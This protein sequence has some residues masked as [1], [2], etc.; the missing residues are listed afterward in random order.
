MRRTRLVLVSTGEVWPVLEGDVMFTIP[1]FIQPEIISRCDTQEAAQSEQDINARVTILKRL[2]ELELSVER[3]YSR[4]LQRSS[5]ALH[6]L[7]RRKPDEWAKVTVPTVAKSVMWH[8][9]DPVVSLLCVHKCLMDQPTMYVADPTSYLSTQSFSV[10]PLRQQEELRRASQMIGRG[11]P[12]VGTLVEKARTLITAQRTRSRTTFGEMVAVPIES[13]QFNEDE[14]VLI[15]FLID[16]VR[17]SR[18]TQTDPYIVPVATL[19]KKINMVEV[20]RVDQA[21][22]HLLL[23]EMG[24]LPPWDDPIVRDSKERE[25]AEFTRVLLPNPRGTFSEDEFAPDIVESLRHD[26]GGLP[27][28]VIDEL[29]AHELDDGISIE[30]IPN[31]PDNHWVHVHIADPTSVLHPNHRLFKHAAKSLQ[32]LYYVHGAN[33]MIPVDIVQQGLSLGSGKDGIAKVMSFSLKVDSEGE[34]TDYRVRPA[35][36]RNINV[37]SYSDVD[38]AL[39]TCSAETFPF[40]RHTSPPATRQLSPTQTKD[41]KTLLQVANR[42]VRP[43]LKA[44]VLSFGLPRAT[45][46]ATSS[47]PP[48]ALQTLTPHFFDGFPRLEYSV[49]DTSFVE[50]GA[51]HIVSESMKGAA[52]VASRFCR[53]KG[54]SAIRRVATPLILNQPGDMDRLL[55]MRDPYGYVSLFEIVK[56]NGVFPTSNYSL[57]PKAHWQIGVPD[58]EGYCRVTSPLRRYGDMVA[59]WNIKAALLAEHEGGKPPMFSEQY[60]THLAKDMRVR[61]SHIDGTQDAD[62][63]YWYLRFIENWMGRATEA[64]KEEILG[65]LAAYPLW[66]LHDNP[67]T[68]GGITKAAIPA[69][70]TIAELLLPSKTTSIELGE[71][72]HVRI[73]EFRF[74]NSPTLFVKPVK[75]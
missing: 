45:V 37:V 36:V 53:D 5:A 25:A 22:V 9:V 27:V 6:Y 8:S 21:S 58:G 18:S 38:H 23:V 52:R 13:I 57:Q 73:S 17:Q 68:G 64:Q 19:F 33:P 16:F 10:R 65:S 67:T 59:H 34:I 39:D 14:R 49:Q 31:E 1:D 54:I 41:L 7:S 43:R 62:E 11:H 26:F 48:F 61:E 29:E 63:K 35:F 24:V 20:L 55:A 71:P 56:S 28:Y 40:G 12:A 30:A 46:V 44:N 32:T 2:K 69:L 50:S 66:P 72:I 51:R 3:E 15:H 74:G 70:G 4:V 47:P 60:L 42:L 75:L